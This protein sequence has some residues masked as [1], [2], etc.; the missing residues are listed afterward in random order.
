MHISNN[1]ITLQNIDITLI[2]E[3]PYNFCFSKKEHTNPSPPTP[4]K[5]QNQQQQ[6][7]QKKPWYQRMFWHVIKIEQA[8]H[9]KNDKGQNQIKNIIES[10]YW[11][12]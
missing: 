10:N 5:I 12:N 7:Q 4:Q 1:I 9:K 6:Q 8:T 3:F 11:Q 2:T